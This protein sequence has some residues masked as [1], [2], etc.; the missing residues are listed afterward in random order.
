MD[1]QDVDPAPVSVQS[2]W[3]FPTF[4]DWPTRPRCGDMSSNIAPLPIDRRHIL[5]LGASAALMLGWPGQLLALSPRIDL[6]VQDSRF[7]CRDCPSA[8]VTHQ[9]IEGDVSALWSELL[10]D[11]WRWPGFVVAGETGS[12]VLFALEQLAI[13]RGR[14]VISRETQPNIIAAWTPLVRWTIGP[15]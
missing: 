8:G 1:R 13:P 6:F 5:K 15:V 7:P 9:L 2:D 12:D 4:H 3:N 10:D 11:A 14:R